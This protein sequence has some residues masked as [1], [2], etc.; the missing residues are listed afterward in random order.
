[1]WQRFTMFQLC[2]EIN[3]L[4]LMVEIS[5]R[6]GRLKDPYNALNSFLPFSFT[7]RLA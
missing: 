6:E 4:R 7:Q 3:F 1:M 2:G 5:A